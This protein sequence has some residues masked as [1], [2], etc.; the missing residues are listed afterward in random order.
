[1]VNTNNNNLFAFYDGTIKGF[2]NS[3]HDDTY[4]NSIVFISGKGDSSNSAIY[5]HGVYFADDKATIKT[6]N[7]NLVLYKQGSSAIGGG[8]CF[9]VGDYNF[10]FG[11]EAQ[12]Y[13][14]HNI[15]FGYYTNIN[16]NYNVAFGDQSIIYNGDHNTIFGYNSISD[17]SHCFVGGYNNKTVEDAEGVFIYGKELRNNSKDYSVAFGQFNDPSTDTLFSIGCGTSANRKNAITVSEKTVRA[18]DYQLFDKGYINYTNKSLINTDSAI[19]GRY[20]ISPL[21][22]E[23][24]IV[25]D[26]LATKRI[27]IKTPKNFYCRLILPL[28]KSTNTGTVYYVNE[29][30]SLLSGRDSSSVAQG[31]Y[32]CELYVYDYIVS[33]KL[34]L[35]TNSSVINTELPGLYFNVVYQ[36]LQ[37]PGDSNSSAVIVALTN[38]DLSSTIHTEKISVELTINGQRHTAT[39]NSINPWANAYK[40]YYEIYVGTHMDNVDISDVTVN[41]QSVGS[42]FD[43][44]TAGYNLCFDDYYRFEA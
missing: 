21:Y 38:P 33:Y 16:G 17:S 18:H 40:Y 8:N 35:L 13:G 43:D 28:Y 22:G 7:N 31:H 25:P 6:L 27:T 20:S 4:K 15:S 26:S 39:L 14:D 44:Y 24:F 36:I 12:A 41:G 42:Y 11:T 30:T 2:K 19:G 29:T 5:T 9:S 10:A 32:L 37:D 3:T 23:T 1:M 34:D